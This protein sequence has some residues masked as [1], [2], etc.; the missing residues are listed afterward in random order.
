[1]AL[2]EWYYAKEG[3][4]FGPISAAGIK[5]MAEAG[6]LA[7]T[8]LVWR[9][10][11]DNWITADKVRGLFGEEGAATGPVVEPT[12]GEAQPPQAA[13]PP[14]AAASRPAPDEPA[15]A[16]P[17]PAEA[18]RE[19]AAAFA[20]EPRPARHPRG[21]A[22]GG[23]LFDFIL[24]TAREAFPQSFVESTADLFAAIGYW[25]LY[26][27][28]AALMIAAAMIDLQWLAAAVVTAVLLAILQ[29]L[30]GR[31]LPLLKR[32]ND[33]AG[34]GF[35]SAVI[36]DVVALLAL[37]G[38]IV[39]VLTLSVAA[40]I[41]HLM[42]ALW[43]VKLFIIIEFI[44]FL[45]LNPAA[46]KITVSE[47]VPPAQA[48]LGLAVFFQKLLL[49]AVPVVFGTGVVWGTLYLVYACYLALVGEPGALA[50]DPQLHAK[51]ASLTAAGLLLFYALLPTLAVFVFPL[52]YLPV[53]LVQAILEHVEHT[54]PLGR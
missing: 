8:D 41:H 33:Q 24:A 16:E 9:E 27:A 5:R 10:G 3:K 39:A 34:A 52:V 2:V 38:G 1:M 40:G 17:A 29:Y 46:L 30:A 50:D 7:P 43:G 20:E 11:L 53:R 22:G 25:G 37:V 32:L 48:A 28:M 51:I 14:A 35:P 13:A 44:A 47:S 6:T 49:R 18:I 23:H 26:G 15:A 36:L 19:A 12:P 31:S 42:L 45:A 54:K 21:G 4:Q